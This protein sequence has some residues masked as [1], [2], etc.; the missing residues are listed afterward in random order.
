MKLLDLQSG[1]RRHSDG[2][3]KSIVSSSRSDLTSLQS[4]RCLAFDA[5][6]AAFSRSCSANARLAMEMH[7]EH[8]QKARCIR[9][10][11]CSLAGEEHLDVPFFSRL[12]SGIRLCLPLTYG[13]T[14]YDEWSN[15]G[16]PNTY[17]LRLDGSVGV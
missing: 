15:P 10:L 7:Y 3:D 12:P 16:A 6:F 17:R 9:Y 1:T 13:N 5:N 8:V 14:G 2:S 4:Y 11:Q